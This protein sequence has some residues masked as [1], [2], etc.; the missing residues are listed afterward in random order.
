MKWKVRVVSL[1]L[2]IILSLALVVGCAPGVPSELKPCEIKIDGVYP[3]Q[4]GAG[5]IDYEVVFS[6]YNPNPIMVVLDTLEW[7]ISTDYMTILDE[8]RTAVLARRLLLDDV[9]I[10]AETEVKVTSAFAVA[11]GTVIGEVFMELGAEGLKYL[12]QTMQDLIETGQMDPESA[13]G[14]VQ[15]GA[16]AAMFP[17]WKLVGA[18]RPPINE[19]LDPYLEL[20]V[21]EPASAGPPIWTASGTASFL[22]AAG[23][24]EVEFQDQWHA[25]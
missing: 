9:Y 21:W 7:N 19:S 24:L 5:S 15:V 4:L 17:L 12:P 11:L 25:E 13:A 10:P 8:Q 1:A 2:S 16:I 14:M 23:S 6:I 18:S 22:S 3:L 20:V